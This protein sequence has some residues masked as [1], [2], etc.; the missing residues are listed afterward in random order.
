MKKSTTAKASH[1][2]TDGGGG[3]KTKPLTAPIPVKNKTKEA[4]STSP[5][6]KMKARKLDPP[7]KT[8]SSPDP[9]LSATSSSSPNDHTQNS[10]PSSPPASAKKEDGQFI[11]NRQESK[12]EAEKKVA[13][14][15]AYAILVTMIK[16]LSDEEL[17]RRKTKDRVA[18]TC[19]ADKKPGDSILFENPHVSGQR[20]K[21]KIPKTTKPGATFKVTV[22][23]P[24]EKE[25]TTKDGGEATDH[26][27][28][29]R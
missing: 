16:G 27:R 7:D 21:V 28:W 25:D 15:R 17:P 26:N 24:P 20:L 29:S 10:K 6:P 13:M 19:P 23:V 5:P 8:A 3:G 9:K 2:S 14:E 4:V 22:P 18:L 1:P 11:V 12:I